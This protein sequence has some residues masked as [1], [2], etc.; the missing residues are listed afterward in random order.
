MTPET[1]DLITELLSEQE[2]QAYLL[3]PDASGSPEHKAA[4]FKFAVTTHE[5]CAEIFEQLQF[6]E[7]L[8]HL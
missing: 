3:D 7:L 8:Y 6:H 4:A 1:K 5:L 2:R